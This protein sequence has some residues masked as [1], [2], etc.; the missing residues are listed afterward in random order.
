MFAGDPVMASAALDP[1][2][3]RATIIN[4]KGESYR[5]KDNRKAGLFPSLQHKPEKQPNP[6]NH[7]NLLLP[8][9]S[10]QTRVNF[11][12]PK[13]GQISTTLDRKQECVRTL[14]SKLLH[15]G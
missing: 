6:N 9:S 5:L 10:S 8:N 3:H 12:C 13:V 4:I 7:I 2:L 15:F 1:L 11:R 14:G